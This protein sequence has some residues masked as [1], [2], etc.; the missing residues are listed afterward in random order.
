MTTA[1]L[2][3]YTTLPTVDAARDLARE[4]V[5]RQLAAC[6]QIEAIESFYIWDGALQQDAEWR[7]MFKTSAARYTDLEAA[8]RERHPYELPAIHAVAVSQA[9]EP[10]ADWVI[11]SA[12]PAT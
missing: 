3:V 7:V 4:M 10:Y 11:A 5:T 8:I 2:T 1:L 12:T 6:A 9:F